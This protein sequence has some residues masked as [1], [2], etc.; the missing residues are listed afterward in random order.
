MKK[1]F[2]MIFVIG[3]WCNAGFA[4]YYELRKCHRAKFAS[5]E[6]ENNNRLAGK[7]L[8]DVLTINIDAGTVTRTILRDSENKKKN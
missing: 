7:W 2:S 5:Y 3:L 4:D 1:L 8:D 6:E